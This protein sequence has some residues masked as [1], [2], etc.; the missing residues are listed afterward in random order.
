MCLAGGVTSRSRH[1]RPFGACARIV[2]RTEFD[3]TP[4]GG[5]FPNQRLNLATALRLITSDSAY[6]SL[7]EKAR[8]RIERG[9]YADLVALRENLFKVRTALLR[10]RS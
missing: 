10:A 2:T 9:N 7:E 6:A 8:G 4:P 1:W 5:W 3:G